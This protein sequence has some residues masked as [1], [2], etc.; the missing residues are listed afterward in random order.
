M[1]LVYQDEKVQKIFCD[2]NELQKKIHVEIGR[3]VK[4]R[5][6][7]LQAYENFYSYLTTFGLGRPHQLKGEFSN[8]FGIDITKNYRL[9]VEPLCENLDMDSLKECKTIKIKGVVDYHGEKNNWIIP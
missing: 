6:N 5:L 3:K 4:R 9:I 8:C 7:E 2:H 1:Q